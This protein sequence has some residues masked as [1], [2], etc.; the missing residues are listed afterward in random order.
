MHPFGGTQICPR[1]SKAVYAAEQV[2]G[3][4]RKLY[5]KPCLACMICNKR[6]DSFT[7]LEHDQMPYCKSCHIKSFGTRDLRQANLP[8][9]E[10][11]PPPERPQSR[12]N[13]NG[14]GTPPP[15]MS[16]PMRS[17]SNGTSAPPRLRPNRSLATSPISSSFPR[18]PPDSNEDQ[19]TDDANTNTTASEEERDTVDDAWGTPARAS[20]FPA[21]RPPP[22]DAS[23]AGQPT[24]TGRP[25]L[26]GLPRTVP[27]SPTRTGTYSSPSSR[28]YTSKSVD[29]GSMRMKVNLN[30]IGG[31]GIA[32]GGTMKP[33]VQTATGTRYGAALGGSVGVQLTGN[34]GSPRKWG[35]TTPTCPRCG[36]SVYFAEQVKA[37]GKTFHKGCLRCTE[38]STLLDSSRLRD[39][40]GEPLCVRCYSKLH[41]PQGGGY[42]LLGKAGG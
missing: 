32:G 30:E 16:S 8:H 25:G 3:P 6:L 19:E 1:C 11:T 2:M 9:R 20:P 34:G 18:V 40:D 29:S 12:N 38:C 5:H 35:G 37:V 4:G 28:H 21:T 42:A 33:L 31:G 24:N 23:Y 39:H 7:L 15:R 22:L 14:V 13:T 17:G 27:L 10:A 36:K 41:G 26:G